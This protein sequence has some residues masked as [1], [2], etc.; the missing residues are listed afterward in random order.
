MPGGF[1]RIMQLHLINLGCARNQVD[2]EIMAGRLAQA[3]YAIVDD[4][5]E[6]EAIIV[7]TCCFVEDAADESVDT[8]LAAAAYKQSG[9]CRRLIVT[10]CLPERYREASAEAL[11]EVDL[12]LG[13]GAYD[14]ILA[15][16]EDTA[17]SDVNCLLPDPDRIKPQGADTP[18]RASAGPMAYIK[19]AEGCDRHCTFCIIPRLRGRQKSRPLADIVAEA[20][21]LIT[22]GVK[23]LVLVAQE[24]TR[25]GYDRGPGENLD[26]LLAALSDL[27]DAIWIRFLYGH[28]QSLADD[29]LRR[30]AERAN[31]CAYFDIPI[32]HGVD[33]V[34]KRMG[35]HYTV[36]DVTAMLTRIRSIV[37]DAALRTT[38]ITGF[39]G[40]TH[41]DFDQ[42]VE[43][44]QTARF[45]H[46]GV[47]SY[48]DAND[49]AS[50]RLPDPVAPE[51]ALQ[52]RDTL[53]Q[54][55]RALSETALTRFWGRQLTVLVEEAPEPGVFLGRTAFQAPEVD[56]LTYI[57]AADG[58]T[59]VEIGRFVRV[60]ITDT[61]EY[62]LVGESV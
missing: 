47:F 57:H 46:L 28:P 1:G 13:T 15:A 5:G 6:A 50:H 35:R 61:L 58:N 52:R 62:D 41:Q 43:F 24:S 48:S 22:Q 9:R 31:L 39:P 36:K 34:L 33:R 29:V 44:V 12:F 56:G 59:P 37:P 18:R 32:Q 40:E 26:T 42:L 8:I 25:Y 3:G 27:S 49:L 23:E 53:M 45:D 19:I 4:P 16:V 38:L 51:I 54:A 17:P 20:Q 30:V 21:G 2:S 7:N 10:G 60:K 11:P 55:Q 14:Q